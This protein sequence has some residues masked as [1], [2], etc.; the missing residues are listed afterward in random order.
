MIEKISSKIK[1]V[2]ENMRRR[3][4]KNIIS[5]IISKEYWLHYLQSFNRIRRKLSGSQGN[6][7]KEF[8]KSLKDSNILKFKRYLRA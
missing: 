4:N 1:A 6:D 7:I 3:V 8:G 2:I 5:C